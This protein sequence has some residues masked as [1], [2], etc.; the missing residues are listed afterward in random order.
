M[1]MWDESSEHGEG[2]GKVV[3]IIAGAA[4]LGLLGACLYLDDYSSLKEWGGLVAFFLC[5]WL[6]IAG[7]VYGILRLCGIRPAFKTRKGTE[8][9]KLR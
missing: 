7:L 6:A 5:P 9:K 2:T 8:D 3:M 4:T 1:A